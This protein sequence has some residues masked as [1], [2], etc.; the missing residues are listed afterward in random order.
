MRLIIEARIV[1]ED[2]VSIA[3]IKAPPIVGVMAPL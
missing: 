3:G 2:T 1:D